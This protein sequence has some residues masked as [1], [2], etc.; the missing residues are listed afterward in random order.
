MRTRALAT[1]C[2]LLLPPCGAAAAATTWD[3]I[4][5]CGF[6]GT[7][8]DEVS[9]GFYLSAYPGNNLSQVE[10]GYTASNGHA[11]LWSVSLTAHRGGYDGPIIGTTQIATPDV[12]QI[13]SGG[14]ALVIFDFGGAPVTP[15]D[16]IAF[17]QTA[18]ELGAT[19]GALDFD[20]G[21]GP[22]SNVTETVGTNPPL[23]SFRRATVGVLVTEH[24]LNTPCVASDT[25]MC[26][27]NF[28]GDQR[29]K[30][31]VSFHTTQAGGA[32]G[33]GR[34]IPLAPLGLDQGGMFWFFNPNN[35]EMLVKVIDGCTVNGRFW[36]FISAGTNVGYSITVTDTAFGATRTY[37][38][39][40]LTPAVPVQDTSALTGCT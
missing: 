31:T 5:G 2:A 12:P 24:K 4:A 32:S 27:D 38:N 8:G 40:D 6:A 29:F 35:P 37:T 3:L 15:G 7:G 19:G 34:E 30:A 39:N 25:V 10:M 16:V 33:N 20:T 9:R 14:E 17:T 1:L 18:Q 22:C 21:K 11:G 28:P 23:D 26:I 13:S 36:V